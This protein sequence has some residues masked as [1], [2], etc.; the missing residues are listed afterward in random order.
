MPVPD[1]SPSRDLAYEESV[2]ME[3]TKRA[4]KSLEDG[5]LTG[6]VISSGGIVRSQVQGKCPRCHHDLD[7]RQTHTAITNVFGGEWRGSA[8]PGSAEAAETG[9]GLTYCEVDVSCGCA[10]PHEGAPAGRHGCG[11]SFR[12]ELEVQAGPGGRRP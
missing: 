7:D 10:H 11:I 6:E 12:V 9:A 8:P 3:W 5:D 1:E 2:D 4:F